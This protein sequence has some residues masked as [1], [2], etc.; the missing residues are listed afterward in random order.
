MPT[1]A[2]MYTGDNKNRLADIDADMKA[3]AEQEKQV[4][5]RPIGYGMYEEY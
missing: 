4:R 5:R 2:G 1:P 3:K